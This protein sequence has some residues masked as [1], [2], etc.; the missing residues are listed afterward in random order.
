MSQ[1][2][3]MFENIRCVVEKLSMINGTTLWTD[4]NLKVNKVL[5]ML[6]FLFLLLFLFDVDSPQTPSSTYPDNLLTGPLTLEQIKV[7]TTK[8]DEKQS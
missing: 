7:T 5:V 8:T 4:F 3:I 1:L 6:Q 2:K